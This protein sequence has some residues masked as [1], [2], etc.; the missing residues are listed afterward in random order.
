MICPDCD[1]SDIVK[2]GRKTSGK[3]N[4]MCKSC[5]RQFVENPENR[6]TKEIVGVHIGR[7]DREGVQ[8]LRDSLPGV[9]RQCAVTYTDFWSA[10]NEVFPSLRHRPVEKGSGKTDHIE[11]FNRTMRQR[12]SRLVRKTLSF[13]KKM[14]NH[15]GA[16]WNFIHHYNVSLA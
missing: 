13:S 14:T 8:K 1:S 4:F 11:S 9:Y 7:R 16:I 3:Q 2:N 5:N 15:I 12:I 6:D 10:Y